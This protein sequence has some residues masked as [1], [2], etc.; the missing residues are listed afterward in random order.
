MKLVATEVKTMD[1]WDEVVASLKNLEFRPEFLL[2]E[3]PAPARL[4]PKSFALGLDVVG[5]NDEDLANGRFVV[6]HDPEGQETWNGTLR[7]VTFVS[8]PIETDV[9]TDE[10]FDDVAWSWLMDALSS[11]VDGFHNIS[12]T[13][14]RT[15]SKSFAGI[16]NREREA[17]VEIRASW[18]PNT[19]NV[20]E[21]LKVWLDF[22]EQSAGL[23]PLPPGVSAISRN[24]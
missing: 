6:L 11:S 19:S 16:E 22:V 14:T 3:V 21:Q 24:R 20:G 1:T 13:V 23:A 4:A 12:G 18:T 10:L 2:E 7:I 15:V 8:A 9:V 17:D 5:S